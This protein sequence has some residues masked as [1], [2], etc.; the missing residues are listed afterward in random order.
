MDWLYRKEENRVGGDFRKKG[1]VF[2]IERSRLRCLFPF[3]L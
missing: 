1:E 3:A 2:K